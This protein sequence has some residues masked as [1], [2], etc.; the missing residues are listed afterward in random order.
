MGRGKM[1]RGSGK[2]GGR[3]SEEELRKSAGD[4]R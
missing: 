1:G 2:V 4:T 3:K